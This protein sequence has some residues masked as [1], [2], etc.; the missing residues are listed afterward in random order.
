MIAGAWVLFIL[1][2]TLVPDVLAPG[3]ET[4]TDVGRWCVVC[5]ERGVADAVLNVG[6]FVPLG[7]ALARWRGAVLAVALGVGLS[8]G[9]EL[10]QGGIEGRFSTF[11]DVVFNGLGT[12]AGAWAARQGGRGVAP[13]LAALAVAGLVGPFVLL[14]PAPTGGVFYGQWTAEFGNLELYGGQMRSATLGGVEV[15]DGRS[16]RS[17]ALRR[18]LLERDSLVVEFTAGPAPA[19]LAPVF[20][21]YDHD[22]V[23][24]LLLGIDGEDLIFHQRT[25]SSSLRL[26]RPDLV[27]RGALAGVLPEDAV[28]V[29]LTWGAARAPCLS[30][31]RRNTCDVAPGFAAGWTLLLYPLPLHSLMDDSRWLTLVDLLWAGAMALPLGWL[32]ARSWTALSA[33]L[34]VAA[35]LLGLSYLSADLVVTPL[36]ALGLAAGAL[37]GALLRAR[38]FGAEPSPRVGRPRLRRGGA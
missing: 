10:A 1:G 23:E 4:P 6:L 19:G 18:A 7:W 16:R 28:R 25:R 27:F 36:P 15:P 30:L 21:I 29:T 35:L 14:A 5:G 37:A 12:A 38:G 26:D 2:L 32:L 20:S 33:S 9:I 31:N 13:I 24:I 11:G 17:A 34:V 3:A 8:A 22:R